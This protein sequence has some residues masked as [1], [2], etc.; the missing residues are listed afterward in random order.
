MVPYK[1]L[2]PLI[3]IPA[4]AGIQALKSLWIPAFAGMTRFLIFHDYIKFKA[5]EISNALPEPCMKAAED[6]HGNGNSFFALVGV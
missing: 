6:S 3:V 1:V 2:C 5:V 4:K